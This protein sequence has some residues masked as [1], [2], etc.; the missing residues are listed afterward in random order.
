MPIKENNLAVNNMLKITSPDF[1]NN[2]YIPQKFA[3][4]GQSQRPVISISGVPEGAKS[5]AMIMDDPD[6]PNGTFVHWVVANIPTNTESLENKL[7]EGSIEGQNSIKKIGWISP[8]PPTGTHHYHFKLYALDIM[9]DFSS[10]DNKQTL[11]DLMN[12][13]I[14]ENTEMIGLYEKK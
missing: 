2:D 6:A 13:H 10:N 5:L 3:C 7:P 12:G 14:I 1:N 11:L 4:D 9:L 8:C